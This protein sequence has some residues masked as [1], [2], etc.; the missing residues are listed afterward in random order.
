MEMTMTDEQM[1]L[2]V[3]MVGNEDMPAA[4]EAA[5]VSRA[6]AD[7]WAKE[8]AFQEELRRRRDEVLAEA[9][10]TVK[11]HAVRA[12]TKLAELMEAADDRVSRHA[13]N[14]ILDHALKVREQDDFERRLAS[15]EKAIEEQQKEK[16]S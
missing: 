2:L 6:T 5:G 11:T 1:K 13:C 8:P 14:D 4:C 9:L 16:E 10:A 12:V 3:A 7:R 15:L